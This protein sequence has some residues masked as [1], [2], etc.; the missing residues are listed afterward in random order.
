MALPRKPW[1]DPRDY[2]SLG[3]NAY[4]GGE[5]EERAQGNLRRFVEEHVVPWEKGS[6]GEGERT[7]T[8]GG[9]EVWWEEREGVKVVSSDM[10]LNLFL[11]VIGLIV[12]AGYAGED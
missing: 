2:D 10:S 4:E 3:S 5:G 11:N 12:Y 7:R 6:W 9:G 8:L 1:E